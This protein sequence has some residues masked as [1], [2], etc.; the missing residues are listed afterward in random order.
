M[1]L[2]V[3]KV[4]KIFDTFLWLLWVTVQA[5]VAG[6]G[7]TLVGSTPF[8]LWPPP[9]HAPQSSRRQSKLLEL[10][11]AVG[12]GDCPEKEGPPK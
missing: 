10:L 2:Y 6:E 3:N 1:L 9:G 7:A 8:L 12:G 4:Q 5:S 11:L